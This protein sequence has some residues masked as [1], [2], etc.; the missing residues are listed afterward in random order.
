LLPRKEPKTGEIIFANAGSKN[1][2][3][4]IIKRDP[5]YSSGYRL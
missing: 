2:I 3:G 1:E 5:F 4:K